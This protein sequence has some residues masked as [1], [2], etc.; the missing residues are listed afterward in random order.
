MRDGAMS[1]TKQRLKSV[2]YL[3]AL[4]AAEQASRWEK[5]APVS[6][7]DTRGDLGGDGT[8][9][10]CALGA[11]FEPAAAVSKPQSEVA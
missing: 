2:S 10:P 9:A 11:R 5:G 6:R 1:H 3:Q 8:R 4:D 7:G